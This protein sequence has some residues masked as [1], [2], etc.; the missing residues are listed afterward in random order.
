MKTMTE[1]VELIENK[2]L[3]AFAGSLQKKMEQVRIAIMQK[4]VSGAE[5]S[6]LQT[7]VSEFTE[8]NRGKLPQKVAGLLALTMLTSMLASCDEF[9]HPGHGNDTGEQE[10][11]EIPTYEHLEIEEFVGEPIDPKECGLRA[12][13]YFDFNNKFV[14]N[15][16]LDQ[17][18]TEIKYY[19]SDEYEHKA[20]DYDAYFALALWGF[21]DDSYG[22]T[23]F[24]IDIYYVF[25]SDWTHKIVS[26]TN[27]FAMVSKSPSGELFMTGFVDG[28]LKNELGLIKDDEISQLQ[29]Q[30]TSVKYNQMVDIARKSFLG[31]VLSLKRQRKLGGSGVGALQW[32]DKEGNLLPAEE[33]ECEVL[34][35]IFL[36]E[37]GGI[38]AKSNVNEGIAENYIDNLLENE[39]II[40][41]TEV[42]TEEERTKKIPE[43]QTEPK[44][45]EPIITP[46]DDMPNRGEEVTTTP[47]TEAEIEPN[48][49]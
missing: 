31:Q 17:F 46:E 20:G 7:S 19:L 3:W 5:K 42:P 28:K 24:E 8:R 48:A 47:E 11:I 16:F 38:L 35:L 14:S 39:T 32:Y 49:D 34:G 44:W 43:R 13:D 15:N 41:V 33:L 37:N 21:A 12:F 26:T 9:G 2:N 27:D 36:H 22:R 29:K 6:A 25:N 4:K 18:E 45:T 1:I 10:T 23:N 30:S 40:E